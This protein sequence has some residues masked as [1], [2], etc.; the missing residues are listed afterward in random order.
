MSL[1]LHFFGYE[2]ELEPAGATVL[3]LHR[4]SAHKHHSFGALCENGA[5]WQNLVALK[6]TD[7]CTDEPRQL[8][9]HPYRHCYTPVAHAS[10]GHHR[11]IPGARK[12]GAAQDRRQFD[13]IA[14]DCG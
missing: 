1:S 3:A 5:S 13:A 11:A 7:G 14:R 8:E 6:I 2:I 9:Q 4:N 12:I 10:R